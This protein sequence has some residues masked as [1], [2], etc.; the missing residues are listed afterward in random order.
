MEGAEVAGGGGGV[1]DGD[2]LISENF[3]DAFYGKQLMFSWLGHR[4]FLQRGKVW[5]VLIDPL[6]EAS[7]GF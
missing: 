3:E 2:G 6:R 5:G 4:D 1:G 7:P